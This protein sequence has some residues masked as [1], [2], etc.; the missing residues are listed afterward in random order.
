M[1]H[2]HSTTKNKH[3]AELKGLRTNLNNGIVISLGRMCS[4]HYS[5]KMRVILGEFRMS[6][7][8]SIVCNIALFNVINILS[9]VEMKRL[10]SIR[11]QHFQ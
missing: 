7:S 6:R 8:P 11:E 3:W 5:T 1:F 2:S 4:G 10:D 9:L